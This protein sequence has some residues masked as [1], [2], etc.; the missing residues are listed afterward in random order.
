ML[1]QEP[2]GESVESADGGAVELVQSGPAAVADL[3]A[4]IAFLSPL[5]LAA[6]AV[7]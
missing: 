4:G 1:G 6:D 7:T 3:D 5:E 2:L